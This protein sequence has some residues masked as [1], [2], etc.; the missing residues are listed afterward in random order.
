MASIQSIVNVSIERA[1]NQATTQD[2]NTIA[3]LTEH[4]RFAQEYKVYTTLKE[5][6]DDGFVVGD[7]AYKYA[8]I[9][10]SQ[11]PRAPQ[12][13]VG[14]KAA[15]DSYIVAIQNL[16]AAYN[17]WLFLITDAETDVD[18]TAIA[19]Y[20]ETTEK[21]Y[22]LHTADADALTTAEGGEGSSSTVELGAA[23]K[24]L[25]YER[26]FGIYSSNDEIGVPAAGWLGRF[27]PQ[28]LGSAIWIYKPIVGITPDNFTS[29]Q[30]TNLRNKNLNCYTT[31]EGSP[32]VFGDNKVFGGEYIDV[33]LGVQWII[34]RMRERVWG[35]L[36][37]SRKVSFDTA[38]IA[39]IESDIRSV[40]AEATD[41][42]ILAADFAPVITV[43]NALALTSAQ[44]N[45]RILTGVTFEA[46]LAGAIQKV[47]GIRGTVFA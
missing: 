21:F 45:T 22:V 7:A 33:M 27:A 9:I 37:N 34:T 24:A 6:T 3:I 13:V 38:G 42:G 43:P 35:T 23:L 41:L 1:T 14:K 36:L 30:L 26:T 44:R 16:E 4:T 29:T 11:N 8:Q 5:M 10:F 46:R 15:L 19:A 31:V 20:I 2:L 39:K 12:V 28:Q 40:L 17:Q 18:H 32:V 47:D 25:G